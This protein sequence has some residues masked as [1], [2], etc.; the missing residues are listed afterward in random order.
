VR[1]K[2]FPELW[3]DPGNELLVKLKNKKSH[4]TGR[5]ASCRFLDICGGGLRARAAY[6][7]G[8]CWA[9]DPACFLTQEEI[10]PSSPPLALGM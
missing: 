8:D 7:T 1:E 9:P 3:T 4:S 6:A 2:P 5:C 10:L